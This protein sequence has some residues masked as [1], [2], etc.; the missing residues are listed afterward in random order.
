MQ[1]HLSAVPWNT[2]ALWQEANAFLAATVRQSR[3]AIAESRRQAHQIQ[4]L[5]ELSFPIMDRLC[6]ETCPGCRDVCCQ[7]ALVWADFRDLIFLH[8]AGIPVPDRQLLGRQED[9]CRYGSP[10]GCRLDRIRRPFV[11]TWYQCPA[12][13]RILKRM[14]TEKQ[15]LLALLQ[16]IKQQR[17]RMEHE[18][19][20]ALV[21][22]SARSD[23]CITSRADTFRIRA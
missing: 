11:C 13:T 23:P 22:D 12:Q 10:D 5:L 7:R 15:R 4:Q 8:L 19:I 16:R 20:Q 21:E 3:P 18:F 14:P 9:H 17:R 6:R 2:P 1:S